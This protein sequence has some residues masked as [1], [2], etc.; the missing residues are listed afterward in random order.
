MQQP[1]DPIIEE[2]H[3]TRRK[4]AQRF[5]CDVQRISEDAKRRQTLEGRP[6]WQPKS[7]NKAINSGGDGTVA[8]SK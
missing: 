3:E 4:L 6:V 2:I 5:N 8:G 7:T 1:L